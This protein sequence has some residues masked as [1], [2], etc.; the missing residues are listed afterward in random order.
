MNGIAVLSANPDAVYK[1]VQEEDPIK[2]V[3]VLK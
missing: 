2:Y 1:H 3:R